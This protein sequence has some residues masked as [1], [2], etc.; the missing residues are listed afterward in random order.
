MVVYG[1]GMQKNRIELVVGGLG[2]QGVVY[3]ANMIARAALNRHKFTSSIA[4]YGPESRGSVTTSEVIISD[5]M[6]VGV[7]YP[8]VES[9]NMFIAMHQKAY[10][11]WAVKYQLAAGITI[12]DATLVRIEPKSGFNKSEFIGVPASQLAR[13]NLGDIMMANVILAA[14]FSK[15]TGVITKS[16]LRS[17]LKSHV[18]AKLWDINWEAVEIGFTC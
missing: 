17:F 2:G 10:E 11:D 3:L 16:D 14:V 1:V 4:H 8:V 9:P 18:P 5:T 13:N 15:K 7:D 6:R 12:Y